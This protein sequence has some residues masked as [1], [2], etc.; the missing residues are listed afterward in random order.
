MDSQPSSKAIETP[1]KALTADSLKG[2][3]KK[4]LIELVLSLSDT[5]VKIQED[6]KKVTDLRL[7]HLERNANMTNQYYRRDQLEIS[8]IPPSVKD[9]EMEDEVIEILTEANVKL[10]G[11]PVKRHMLEAAHRIGKANKVVVKFANRKIARTALI[12]KKNL[13]G[14]TRYG[15]ETAIYMN[16]FLIPEFGYLNFVIRS[17]YKQKQLYRYKI[18]NGIS[19]VQVNEDSDFVEIGHANDLVNLGIQVP[20]RK[21]Y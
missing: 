12:K 13:K 16:D 5:I 15:E 17:A 11:K 10:E 4:K 19:S 8:G 1:F 6:Y 7:Y 21:Y 18:R 9:N 20:P 2:L 14:S 3:D